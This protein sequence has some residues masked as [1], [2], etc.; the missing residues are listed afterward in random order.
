MKIYTKTGDSGQTGL[1]GGTR[2]PKN[3]IRIDTYGTVDELNSFIGLLLCEQME[4]REVEFLQSI[5]QKLFKIGSYLATDDIKPDLKKTFLPAEDD[6]KLIEKEIDRIEVVLPELTSF[7]LP[8]GSKS[9]SLSH[10][11]RTITRRAERR[12]YDMKQLYV[13]DSL[14]FIYVN[15]LS[16]YF[17]SLSR[18]LTI[19]LGGKEIYKKS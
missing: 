6:I 9:G 3:D 5:Q 15:R 8:G 10:I 11:C 16:D 1:L 4:T 19:S 17:F 14:I 7:I 12:L 2:V 13:V 18:Y